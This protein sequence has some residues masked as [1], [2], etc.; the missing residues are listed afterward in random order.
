MQDL[1]YALLSPC[2]QGSRCA[3]GLTTQAGHSLLREE[4]VLSN[5]PLVYWPEKASVPAATRILVNLA[6]TLDGLTVLSPLLQGAFQLSLM[7]LVG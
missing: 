7:V 1:N 5:C 4:R 2:L 3:V 6:F